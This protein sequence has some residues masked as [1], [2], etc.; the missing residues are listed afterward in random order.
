MSQGTYWIVAC[1]TTGQGR[2]SIY[3]VLKSRVSKGHLCQDTSVFEVPTNLKFGSFDDLIRLVDELARHDTT[4]ETIIRR[5]ERQGLDIDP[6]A[7][8]KIIWQRNS[9]TAD[10]YLH[11]FRWDD[12][13]YPRNRQMRD[14]MDLL[15]SSVHKLDEEVRTKTAVFHELKNNK[16]GGASGG[17]AQTFFQV[18]LI[19]V[20]TPEKVEAEDFI[21]TEHLT[22]R[23]VVVPR[24]LEANWSN[25]YE[26]FDSFIVPRSTKQFPGVDKDGNTLWR[27]VLFKSCVDAF[28]TAA[29][30]KR[31]IVR[32]FFYSEEKFHL[33]QE[34]RSKM[35]AEKTRQETFLSRVCH[36]GFSDVF[37]A[38]SHLKAMRVFVE[39]VLRFGVPAN[40]GAFLLRI[41]EGKEKKLR[42]ELNSVFTTEGMFGKSYIEGPV[43]NPDQSL[44]NELLDGEEFYPYISLNFVPFLT[45]VIK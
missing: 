27:V 9:M 16:T 8:F 1:G 13:K 28:K 33:M 19:D 14:N 30:T 35:E 29:R 15:V 6:T 41:T 10:Q 2:E 22:T 45:A 4:L 32:D 11:R 37:I 36:A 34:H 12:A 5:I 17:A 20:L 25:L 40:F 18:D 26:S 3:S 42:K 24:G 39:A 31:F 23:V 44:A 38:W 21:E 7:E 43:G